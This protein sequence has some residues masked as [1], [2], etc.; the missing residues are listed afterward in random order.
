MYTRSYVA[1]RTDVNEQYSFL[2]VV[3]QE[4]GFLLRGSYAFVI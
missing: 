3:D 2:S 1:W 4:I